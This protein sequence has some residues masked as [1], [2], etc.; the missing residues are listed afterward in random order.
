MKDNEIAAMKLAEADPNAQNLINAIQL[1]LSNENLNL[2]ALKKGMIELLEYLASPNGRTDANCRAV[3][4]F[5]TFDD[6]WLEKNL[7]EPFHD[8]FADIGGALHDTVSSPDVAENFDS[9]PEQLLKRTREL[10]TE[11]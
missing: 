9:T 8:L 5:F 7:P 6:L 4:G 3:D 1:T 2:K 10:S 11:Q